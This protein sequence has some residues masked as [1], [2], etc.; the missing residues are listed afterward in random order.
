MMGSNT[1]NL[2]DP[3]T[4]RSTGQVGVVVGIAKYRDYPDD[5]LITFVN[6]SGDQDKRWFIWSEIDLLEG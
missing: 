3:V 5:V 4:I 6:G 2:N 1:L